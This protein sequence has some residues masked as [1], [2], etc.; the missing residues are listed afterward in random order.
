VRQ[1]IIGHFEELLNA[2]KF[3]D[4][5]MLNFFFFLFTSDVFPINLSDVCDK[6]GEYIHDGEVTEQMEAQHVS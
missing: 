4:C 1:K 2:C 3:M 6:N 5:R